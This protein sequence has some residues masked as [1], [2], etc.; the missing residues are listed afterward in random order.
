MVCFI[1]GTEI[2]NAENTAL[3]AVVSNAHAEEEDAP[4]Q[5]LFAHARCFQKIVHPSVPFDV[6]IFEDLD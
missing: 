5:T 6:G 2:L 3:K 4:S 1:C